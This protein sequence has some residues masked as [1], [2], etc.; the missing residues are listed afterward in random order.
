MIDL[1]NLS[2]IPAY[3]HGPWLLAALVGLGLAVGVLSGLFGVGGASVIT[4]MMNVL[5]GIPYELGV[6][7]SMSFAI[8]TSASGWPRH[9]QLG[10][11]ATKTMTI[12]AFA[13]IC[14]TLLGKD[15]QAWLKSAVACWGPD[16][17]TL[18]MHGLFIAIL[19]L[20]AW[21][22]AF[23]RP[24]EAR[25]QSLL[26]RLP[27]GPHI[28]IRRANL[29]DVSL[30]GLCLVGL[31]IGI[32]KGLMGIG[33]GVLMMPVMLLVIGM[34]IQQSVGTS[35]GVV[36]FSSGAGAIAYGIEGQANLWIVMALLLGSTIG[37]QIG[38][39]LCQRL[40]AAR[41]QRYFSILI[42]L[43]VAIL[44]YDL[45]CKLAKR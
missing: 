31:A 5:L 18:A 45:I 21:M 9:W 20:V 33:G 8:G 40:Q 1:L 44:A 14:G 36:L 23:W 42:L 15:C 4:P 39:Y 28:E 41:I 3:L 32:L 16:S 6:G 13:C 25:G 26:Q 35:L 11:V 24:H 29:Q 10:N 17:F 19:L 22:V 30:P 2:G 34:S 43:V 27:L 12:L 38:A 37:V 7:C